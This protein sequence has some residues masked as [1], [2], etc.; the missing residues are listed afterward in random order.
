VRKNIT[1]L[2]ILAVLLFISAGMAQ[3]S[4]IS[5]DADY[6]VFFDNDSVE[7]KIVELFYALYP[8]EWT[9]RESEQGNRSGQVV[10][11]LELLQDKSMIY[12]TAWKS[13]NTVTDSMKRNESKIDIMRFKMK[14]GQYQAF[15]KVIDVYDRTKQ[16]SILFN[17]EVPE[18]VQGE[19]SLS[20]IMLC[21][22]AEEFETGDFDI[23]K[24]GSL[25]VEP[26]PSRVFGGTNEVINFYVE[27]YGFDLAKGQ[28]AIITYHVDDE[29]GEINS[30]K[31]GK[32]EK[33]IKLKSRE[34]IEGSINI[35]DLYSGSYWLV[36]EAMDDDENVLASTKRKFFL[37]NPD[38]DKQEKSD[39][40]IRRSKESIGALKLA[41]DIDEDTEIESLEYIATA[42]EKDVIKKLATSEAKIGF[43]KDFWNKRDPD[44]ST[45]VNEYRKIY[46]D[47]VRYANANYGS[48]MD[49]WK[50]DMGRVYILYGKPDNI[51]HHNSTAN[52]RAYQIWRYDNVEG[53]VEFAYIS[54]N[55]FGNYTLVHSTKRG[56]MQNYNWQNLIELNSQSRDYIQ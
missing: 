48:L 3:E 35:K 23:F 15:L 20:D 8:A 14:P 49:G 56:E 2:A 22:K 18:H 54:F 34:G 42:K 51:E 44:L 36:F 47:R 31:Y 11:Q 46:L 37:Y 26:N 1:F 52:G 53:G 5:I 16:D 30:D 33:I 27:M 43:L 25:Y 32:R 9:Y 10:V 55:T 45:V 17:I 38:G 29:Q 13:V 41:G 6:A 12:R 7:T 4:G 28:T 24:R 50:T 21:N 40:A 39:L 19:Y